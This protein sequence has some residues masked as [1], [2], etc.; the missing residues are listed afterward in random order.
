MSQG[1]YRMRVVG[2]DR[3]LKKLRSRLGKT[4][5]AAIGKVFDQGGQFMF[6]DMYRDCPVDTGLLRSTGKI[7]FG[8]WGFTI[9][10]G[11]GA[12]NRS[13]QLYW[14][15]VE[16]GGGPNRPPQPFLQPN[17]IIWS[18]WIMSQVRRT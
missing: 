15:Y 3:V 12:Y 1:M 8:D 16:H 7:V 10:W 5:A 11:E 17:Y 9:E 4:R 18:R 2:K 14:Y 6:Q 13:H